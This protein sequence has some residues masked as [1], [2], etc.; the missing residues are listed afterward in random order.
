[1]LEID[2]IIPVSK[3]GVTSA[4]NLQT[5]CWKC[6]RSK[7]SKVLAPK[8]A[9]PA[10]KEVPAK[11]QPLTAIELYERAKSLHDSGHDEEAK[12]TLLVILKTYPESEAAKISKKLLGRG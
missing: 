4:D 10:T 8:A 9:I 11:E 1:M 5:L 12:R 3:G 7:G 2:H 6:N